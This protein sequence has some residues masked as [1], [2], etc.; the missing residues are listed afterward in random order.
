MPGINGL[1]RSMCALDSHVQNALKYH[2]RYLITLGTC[3]VLHY[4][5]APAVVSSQYAVK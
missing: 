5:I 2:V 4:K 3:N 1:A